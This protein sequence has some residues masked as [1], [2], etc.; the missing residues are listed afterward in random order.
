MSKGVSGKGL[1]VRSIR[2]IAAELG[3]SETSCQRA[4][5]SGM[6]KIRSHPGS[7]KLYEYLLD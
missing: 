5:N 1:Y 7:S 2:E 3:I 6:D 4:F